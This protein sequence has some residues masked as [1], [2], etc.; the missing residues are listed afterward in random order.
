MS[1]RSALRNPTK[2]MASAALVDSNGFIA[3]CPLRAGVSVFT[4]DKYFEGVPGLMVIPF[5]IH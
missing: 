1:W 4:A 3:A 2:N 5:A